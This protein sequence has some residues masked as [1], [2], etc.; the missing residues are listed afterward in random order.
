MW[1]NDERGGIEKTEILGSVLK[2]YRQLLHPKKGQCLV[3]LQGR[4]TLKPFQTLAEA[5]K[6]ANEE[7]RCK[8]SEGNYSALS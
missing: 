6:I 4:G 7:I 1:K 2:G 3:K 8:E 5:G